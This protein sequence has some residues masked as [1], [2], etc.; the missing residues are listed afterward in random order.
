VSTADGR[1]LVSASFTGA[2][3]PARREENALLGLLARSVV[4]EQAGAPIPSELLGFGFLA[5]AALLLTALIAALMPS[6]ALVAQA[7]F[8]LLLGGVAATLT[9]TL[10][11]LGPFTLALG[12]G[13]LALN[14]VLESGRRHAAW[15]YAIV[16]Q[17]ALGAAC[18]SL[19]GLLLAI[20]LLDLTLSIMIAVAF[21]VVIFLCIGAA[22][23][24]L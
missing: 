24:E 22:L 4:H 15:R 23:S 17:A 1:A 7:H 18:L 20:I 12:C 6:P 5:A 21:V 9:G 19:D 10:Q 13:L 2:E 14:L 3:L 11:A 8:F 16:G